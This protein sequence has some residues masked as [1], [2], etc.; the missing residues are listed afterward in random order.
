MKE[1]ELLQLCKYYKGEKENPY[2]DPNGTMWWGGEKQFV[3]MCVKNPQYFE[4]VRSMYRDALE[5][6]ELSHTLTD[7]GVEENR[8]VLVYFLDLW[9]GKWFPH[10]SLDVI[11]SY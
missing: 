4:R 9:H 2:A 5:R 7:T 1:K 8:R 3:D 11:F 6:N 10:D